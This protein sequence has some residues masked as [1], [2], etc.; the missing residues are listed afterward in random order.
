MSLIKLSKKDLEYG[1]EYK[2]STSEVEPEEVF[3]KQDRVNKAF[4]LALSTSSEG[5]NLFVVGPESVGRTTYALRR[6]KEKAQTE[7]VPEDLC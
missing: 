1:Y 4:D 2:I 7:P 3:L 6:L 5:Y